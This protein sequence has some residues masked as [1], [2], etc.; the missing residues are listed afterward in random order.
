MADNPLCTP[1]LFIP[2][3]KQKKFLL[4]DTIVRIFT[5]KWL[6]LWLF[7]IVYDALPKIN[8]ITF[9]KYES[10]CK[11]KERKNVQEKQLKWIK[12]FLIYINFILR[13]HNKTFY[14]A[15]ACTALETSHKKYEFL[16]VS[17]IFVREKYSINKI[18]RRTRKTVKPL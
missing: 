8:A 15:C 11:M 3:E 4:R 17:G 1:L 12:D 14:F 2:W 16:R 6:W 5:H 10:R 13:F 7:L 18:L 9:H